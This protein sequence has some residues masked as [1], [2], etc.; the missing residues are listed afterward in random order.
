MYAVVLVMN[1]PVQ[2]FNKNVLVMSDSS[3]C[4]QEMAFNQ[5]KEVIEAAFSPMA[6]NLVEIMSNK[7]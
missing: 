5:T 2:N 6:G 1:H 3:T 7:T 4:G